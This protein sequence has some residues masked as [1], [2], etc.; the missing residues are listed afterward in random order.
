MPQMPPLSWQDKQDIA[1][2]YQ[3]GTSVYQITK[4]IHRATRTV[5]AV[6][7]EMR[8]ER[9]E[10]TGVPS[11]RFAE[12]VRRYQS[13]ESCGMI[14]PDFNVASHTIRLTLKRHGVALRVSPQLSLS[15]NRRGSLVNP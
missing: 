2:R 11:A 3:G 10:K 9:R 15:A 13:G 8:M 7:D 5:E 1:H 6:L 12:V 14:A 4:Q